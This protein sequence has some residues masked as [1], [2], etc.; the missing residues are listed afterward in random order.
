[1]T[2]IA[3]KIECD[4]RSR[5]DMNKTAFSLPQQATQEGDSNATHG[6]VIAPN[7]LMVTRKTH[8]PSAPPP[9]KNPA[10][11]ALG[12]LGGLKGGVARAKSISDDRKKEIAKQGAS[13][14]WKDR[15][16]TDIKG[17]E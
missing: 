16:Q 13:A 10:A 8:S 3:K 4:N 6:P 7:V 12:R 1:M 14:R 5:R 9:N 11:V 17:Q 2:A 15:K